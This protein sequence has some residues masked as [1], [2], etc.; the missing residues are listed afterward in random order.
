MHVRGVRTKFAAQR[1]TFMSRDFGFG[2]K[3][4]HFITD[5]S[6]QIPHITVA[7]WGNNSKHF[8]KL[9]H[10]INCWSH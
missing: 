4:R 8:L 1:V 5:S 10:F 2:N 3:L 7:L 9:T 6:S